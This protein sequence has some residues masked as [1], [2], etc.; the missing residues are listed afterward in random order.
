MKLFFFMFASLLLVISPAMAGQQMGS[1]V[2]LRGSVAI[3]RPGSRLEAR[4]KS[5][6]ELQ[7]TVQTAAASR[8]KLLFLDDSVLTMGDNSR[9]NIK[10]FIHNSG[11]RGKSIFNLLDGKMRAVVGKTKFQVETPTAVAAARGTVINFEVGKI[12]NRYYTKIICL[13]GSVEVF[14]KV[15]GDKGSLELVQGE[16]VT[17]MEGEPLGLPGT[18]GTTSA[19]HQLSIADQA[20][21]RVDT[22]IGVPEINVPK[23]TL[24]EILPLPG[25][26]PDI[27]LPV[28]PIAGQQ[29][30]PVQPTGVVIRLNF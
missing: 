25:P 11:D 21:A 12:G 3:E 16:S 8:A 4:I 30:P 14:T 10:E 9:M 20:T 27:L 26:G 28:I 17:I 7:D 6:I 19:I 18:T 15:P 24:P 13:E 1:V 22:S 5:G 29:Q 2:A 23:M